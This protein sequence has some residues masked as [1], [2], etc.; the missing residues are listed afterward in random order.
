[1]TGL[2]HDSEL[3]NGQL[4]KGIKIVLLIPQSLQSTRV[5]PVTADASCAFH[6]LSWFPR[7][8]G[9][10]LCEPI[11]KAITH[12]VYAT[13]LIA[14]INPHPHKFSLG[15]HVQSIL[16]GMTLS[17]EKWMQPWW[18]S[19]LDG[20]TGPAGKK[21]LLLTYICWQDAVRGTKVL[22]EGQ[23]WWMGNTRHFKVRLLK[24]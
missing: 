10:F 18:C 23:T 7:D 16:M 12:W 22:S 1:M 5:H 14:E 3:L 17:W 9:L 8:L 19:D 21:W 20:V 6:F 11:G 15:L 2:N 13:I 24:K 4:I